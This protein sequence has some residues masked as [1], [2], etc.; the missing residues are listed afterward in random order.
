MLLSIQV[1]ATVFTVNN[2]P[3]SNAQFDNIQAAHDAASPGDTILVGGSATQYN[4]VSVSKKIVIIGPGFKPNNNDNLVAN[5]SFVSLA[6][7]SAEGS[8]FIGFKSN[9]IS[10]DAGSNLVNF[11][12]IQGC[13]INSIIGRNKGRNWTIENTIASVISGLEFSTIRNTFL[14]AVQNLK[15]SGIINCVFL[16]GGTSSGENL[17]FSNNIFSTAGQVSTNNS[18]FNNNLFTRQDPVATNSSFPV[19]NSFSNNLFGVDPKFVNTAFGNL[20]SFKNDYNLQPDSPA[21][22]AGTDGRDLG[23]YGGQG[24]SNSGEP[25]LPIVTGLLIKNSTLDQNGQLQVEIKGRANN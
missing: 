15:T 9:E 13:E 6:S 3:G 19:S 4:L 11:I 22:G 10:V 7:T 8:V 16:S 5:I 17:L 23:V 14:N 20:F 24:F 1:S 25:P 18:T 2:T 12:S 21:I